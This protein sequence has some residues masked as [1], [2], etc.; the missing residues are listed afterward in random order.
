MNKILLVIQREYATRVRKVS[1]WVLTLLVPIL[2]A[3]L[4]AIPIIM[5]TRPLEHA[6]VLVVDDTG[7][8]QGQF[9]STRDITY[10][11][12]GSLEYAQ[13]QLA[14]VDSLDAIVYIPARETTIPTDAF[15]YYRTDVPSM[16]VQSNVDSQLQEILRNRILLDVH[17]ISADDY[18]MLT[19]TRIRLRTKDIE[20]GRDG[21]LGIKVAVGLILAMLIFIAIFSFGSQVMR[22]VMEEKGSRIVEIIV[23]S[24]RPFQLMMG[25][26]VGIGL[27]G[28]TQFALW[29]LLSGIAVGAL[30]ATNS[31]LFSQAQQEQITQIATKGAEATAQME[32]AMEATPVPELM[33]GLA[34]INF[35]VL[36]V[37]FLFYFVFGYLLYATLFAAVGSLVDTETDSQQFTLPITVPLILVVLLLPAMINQPSGT[38]SVWLSMIPFT[39]PVAM[40]LRIPFGVPIWQVVLSA[41]LLL[42]TFP[43]CIWLAARIYR[44]GILRYGQKTTWKDLARFFKSR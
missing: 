14:E 20:T 40:L 41:L 1:F 6:H 44:A 26:V 18:Q 32:A 2:I 42:A 23:C 35:G 27:V 12:A 24:V 38:L 29:I 13:R 10:H 25:K 34:S 21:F 43:L 22:G 16:T 39:S 4:Y 5:A 17:G 28:L 9:R 37:A 15:L 7:L 3:G 19:S 8:F 11:A 31:E 30:Q 36:L 33:Q